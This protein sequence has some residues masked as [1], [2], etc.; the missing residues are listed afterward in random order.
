M[1]WQLED[2]LSKIEAGES[3]NVRL[4]F[5]DTK[6]YL[7]PADRDF[8]EDARRRR[9]LTF[10]LDVELENNNEADWLLEPVRQ[11]D[12]NAVI[13]LSSV[14]Y[15]GEYLLAG[16]DDLALDADRR[17]VYTWKETGTDFS[18]WGG[19]DEWILTEKQ[20]PGD[21]RAALN[22]FTLRNKKFDEDLY[23]SSDRF[24]LDDKFGTVYTWRQDTKIQDPASKAGSPTNVWEIIIRPGQ[25]QAQ[26][27]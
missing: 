13:R 27:S 15:P 12:K 6:E 19:P 10:P 22:H 25:Q 24:E 5:V 17:K 21:D 16:T 20:N 3:F 14:R 2:I 23:A 8:T 9:V 7:F 18:D 26:K 4:R 1:L 11:Q